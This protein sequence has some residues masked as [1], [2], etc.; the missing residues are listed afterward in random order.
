MSHIRV[1]TSKKK[2]RLN[3]KLQPYGLHV[4]GG[5]LECD[6]ENDK[7]CAHMGI[8]HNGATFNGFAV[9]EVL[10]KELEADSVF[11]NGIRY[12]VSA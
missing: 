9:A 12:T 2:E 8:E 11:I 1:L 10:R 3:K 4:G 5:S 6:I 7:C